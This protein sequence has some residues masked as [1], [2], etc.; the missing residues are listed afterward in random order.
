MKYSFINYKIKD[1]SPQYVT[2][3][4]EEY[5]VLFYRQVGG[6]QEDEDGDISI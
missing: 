1:T 6:L 4:E 2:V 3:E 5:T